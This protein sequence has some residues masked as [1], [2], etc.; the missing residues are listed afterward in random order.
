MKPQKEQKEN[1]NEISPQD[2]FSHLYW[3]PDKNG[4]HERKVQ[5]T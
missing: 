3:N 5:Q 1:I 4:I 2:K